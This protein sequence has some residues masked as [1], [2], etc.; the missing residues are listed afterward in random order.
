MRIP[1]SYRARLNLFALTLVWA[2]VLPLHAQQPG[3]AQEMERRVYEGVA[4][5]RGKTIGTL[6]LL[7]GDADSARGW[8]RLNSFV[9]IDSGKLTRNGAEFRAGS[10]TYTIDEI[11]KRMTYSGPEGEGRRLALRLTRFTG[12]IHE[13]HEATREKPAV[14]KIEV[15]G[16][17]RELAYGTPGLWKRQG[18]PFEKFQRLEEFLSKQ[19]SLWVADV[20]LR[21]GRLVVVEEPQG[22]DI[23]LKAPKQDKKQDDKK[24]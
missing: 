7:E 18:P 23:P 17:D 9:P 1:N 4:S 3:G 11:E 19:V 2:I 10:N 20:D 16:R 13:L 22:M 14:A 15:S 5:W 24:K 12:V 21:Y 8:I 6:I